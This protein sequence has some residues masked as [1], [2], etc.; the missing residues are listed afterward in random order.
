MV[1]GYAADPS[2]KDDELPE[3]MSMTRVMTWVEDC[4]EPED[5]C[6]I[7]FFAQACEWKPNSLDKLFDKIANDLARAVLFS[8][9]TQTVLAPY[10]GGFDVF[11]LQPDRIGYL[12]AKYR[13]W[14]SSRP[15]KL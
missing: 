7:A 12:E 2:P 4:D 1:T 11:S 13:A 10:D 6:E 9:D 8:E 5:Q 14:M 3:L 15:D